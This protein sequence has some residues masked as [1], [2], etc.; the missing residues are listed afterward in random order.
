M[1]PFIFRNN[2]QNLSFCCNNK[3]LKTIKKTAF[4]RRFQFRIY[5]VQLIHSCSNPALS[6][7]I[8]LLRTDLMTEIIFSSFTS[9]RV[10]C[11]AQIVLTL[12][13]LLKSPMSSLS[14]SVNVIIFNTSFRSGITSS[15][16]YPSKRKY[17]NLR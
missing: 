1:T 7:R 4:N 3:R 10:F 14:S 2:T 6:M 12:E 8:S 16:Y 5:I 13:L 17:R 9:L 15:D 11:S